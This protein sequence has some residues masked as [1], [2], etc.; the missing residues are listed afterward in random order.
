MHLNHK[1]SMTQRRFDRLALLAVLLG[2]GL[3]GC[4]STPPLRHYTL[5]APASDA[6]VATSFNFA[7]QAVR[8]P[9]QVD[10]TPLV[11]RD[12][13][14]ALRVLEGHQWGAPLA[15]EWRGALSTALRQSHG[16]VDLA[17]AGLALPPDVPVLRVDLQRFDAEVGVG[18]HAGGVW[19]VMQTDP[20]VAL[21]CAFALSA[22]SGL[23]PVDIARA[24]QQLIGRLA[25][26]IATT[27]SNLRA[28]G[29]PACSG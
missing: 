27:L 8:V 3:A 16:G 26:Q 10:V 20:A 12:G 1:A 15:L 5:Q 24:H 25:T 6:A 11:V 22:P 14:T 18:A 13:D 29:D 9:P 7:L 17:R 2:V 23:M 28:G 4:V 19:S 21:R